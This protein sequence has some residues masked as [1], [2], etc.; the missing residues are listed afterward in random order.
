MCWDN[1]CV[2][3]I[4]LQKSKE[5]ALLFTIDFDSN[6]ELHRSIINMH[7]LFLRTG[8]FICNVRNVRADKPVDKLSDILNFVDLFT[9]SA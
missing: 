8:L 9:C 6:L 5:K 3:I 7:L 1:L 4:K 2:F